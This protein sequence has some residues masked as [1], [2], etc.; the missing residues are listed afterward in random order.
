M[1]F[2]SPI[3]SLLL[4]ASAAL[5]ACGPSGDDLRLFLITA[6]LRTSDINFS[7]LVIEVVYDGGEICGTGNI[8]TCRGVALD[9]DSSFDDQENE[10]DPDDFVMRATLRKS[11][12]GMQEGQDIFECDYASPVTPA[13]GNFTFT[14]ISARD[15]ADAIPDSGDLQD[16]VF[17][18]TADE[19]TEGGCEGVTV[20]TV[21]TTSSSSTT[22]STL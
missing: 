8:M 20:T 17:R 22:S 18:V 7:E 4:A 9:A 15:T 14:I 10:D 16:V 21:T 6:E 3:S 2:P 12:N 13:N 1:K 19:G 11:G 5:A